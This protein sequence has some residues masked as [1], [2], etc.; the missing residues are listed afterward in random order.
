M[1]VGV[2]HAKSYRITIQL[3][4]VPLLLMPLGVE[5][6][7]QQN[8]PYGDDIVPLPLMRL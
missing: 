5:H 8:R 6:H 1:S 2:E 4:E 3:L 7:E